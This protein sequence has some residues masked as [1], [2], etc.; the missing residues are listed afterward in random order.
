[1]KKRLIA[2]V[3]TLCL[4]SVL[5][6]A[7]AATDLSGT[8]YCK[9]ISNLGTNW[10]VEMLGARLNLNLNADGTASWISETPIFP[11]NFDGT[12]EYD[13]ATKEIHFYTGDPKDEENLNILIYNGSDEIHC[14]V[15]DE[16][17]YV[18]FSRE[19]PMI[20]DTPRTVA[21]GKVEDFIGKWIAKYSD[22]GSN[23]VYCPLDISN[24]SG[25]TGN[26]AVEMSIGNKA[27]NVRFTVNGETLPDYQTSHT[28]AD[29]K[30]NLGSCSH[31]FAV[32][33]IEMTEYGTIRMTFHY[34]DDKSYSMYLYF[35]KTK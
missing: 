33:G 32:D 31:F 22:F 24:Q 7:G 20:I 13:D 4:M 21:A 30:L 18:I 29:G 27:L 19:A 12:W 3:M 35:E 9:I 11:E 34:S 25:M 6:P 14:D 23:G 28:F 16:G 5:M 17:S 2:L 15:D 26:W 1:M 10:P 8:W